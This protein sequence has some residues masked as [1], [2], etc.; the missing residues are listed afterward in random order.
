MIIFNTSSVISIVQ[1]KG[2]WR[3]LFSL[4]GSTMTNI[5]STVC[6][7]FSTYGHMAKMGHKEFQLGQVS[8]MIPEY[9]F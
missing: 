8:F 7:R 1:Y 6:Q 4:S 2:L 9:A 3:A 5:A